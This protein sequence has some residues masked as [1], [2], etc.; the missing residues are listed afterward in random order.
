MSGKSQITKIDGGNPTFQK[1]FAK[2]KH[3]QKR[4]ATAAFGTLLMLDIDQAPAKL[5][6]HPLKNLTAR[7]VLDPTKRVKVYTIYITADDRD[8]ASF[9]L[10]NGTAYLRFCGEHDEVD[11]SP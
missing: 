11:K 2:L 6:L 8:K 10:E 1:A 7:S 5:H 4:E 3:Q 9:T